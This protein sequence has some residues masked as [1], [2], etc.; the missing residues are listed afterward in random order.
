MSAN[1]RPAVAGGN[2][3]TKVLSFTVDKAIELANAN[4]IVGDR[5]VAGDITIIP[6]SKLSV[7]FA[8]GGADIA[9]VQ[10]GKQQNPAGAGAKV[11]LTPMSFLVICDGTVQL[12]NI[13]AEE[14]GSTMG[15]VVGA[16]VQQA[17]GL[18]AA[19]KQAKAEAAAE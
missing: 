16:V 17:V 10:R 4:S 6:I 15:D 18:V 13:A 11:T 1:E 12:L 19:A 7:G 9:D 2:T 3:L 8:G 14:G 5:I